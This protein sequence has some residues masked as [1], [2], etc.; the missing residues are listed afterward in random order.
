MKDKLRLEIFRKV[1]LTRRL[2]E[3]VLQ[4]S[5]SGEL[6]PSL[7]PGQGQEICQ[8]ASLAALNQDDPMLY[9]H[10]GMGYWTGR[11]VS[12]ELILCEMAC[13]EGASTRG[14][15]GIM[16][17][18]DPEKGVFGE[19]GTVGTNLVIVA[20][21][22]LAEQ[23]RQ[24]NR[25]AITYFGDGSSNRGQFHEAA[26]FISLK[27]LPVILFCENNGWAVSVPATESTAVEDIA[28]RAA[29]YNMPGVVVDGNDP[30]AVYNATREAA[31]RARNGE[32][33]TL[34]EAKV[35]RIRGHYIGD[36]Q[37]YRDADELEN[38]QSNDPVPHFQQDMLN[39]GLLDDRSVDNLEAEIAERIQQAVE[40]MRK[41]PLIGA[42]TVLDNLY[43]EEYS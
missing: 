19:S 26:N 42:E 25:V 29:G 43:A 40:Y 12:P 28:L 27:K 3:R 36:T 22:G 18:V 16:H 34:I 31:E 4:L 6:F 38:T 11:D 32:G 39:R 21:I 14:K 37:F 15:G 2:E 24:T 17:L 5:M 7:H 1:L 30:E 23:M 33:G 8:I 9:A 41:Q 20:G 10:R 13:R 35:A